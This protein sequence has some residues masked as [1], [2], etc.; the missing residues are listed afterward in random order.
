[1]QEAI[2]IRENN[3]KLDFIKQNNKKQTNNNKR[4][5]LIK[6]TIK[7]T[8]RQA[9]DSLKVFAKHF[10]QRATGERIYTTP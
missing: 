9:T 5:M 1:M 7:K 6:H 10:C 4:L 3:Y 8:R 2:T